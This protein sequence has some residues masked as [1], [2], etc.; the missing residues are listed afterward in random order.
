[1]CSLLECFWPEHKV[2]SIRKKATAINCVSNGLTM[3][4]DC[5][6]LFNQGKFYLVPV[7]ETITPLRYTA[8]FHWRDGLGFELDNKSQEWFMQTDDEV[9]SGQ[10]TLLIS[11]WLNQRF[12]ICRRR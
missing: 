11:P 3:T 4:C 9:V 1:M 5:Y 12:W 10:P 7:N 6:G 8:I 2:H